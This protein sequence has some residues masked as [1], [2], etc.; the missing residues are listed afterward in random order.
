[1]LQGGQVVRHRAHNPKIVSSILTP[2]TKLWADRL[3][4]TPQYK[5]EEMLV[6][7]QQSPTTVR[8]GKC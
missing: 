8:V 2:A 7:V 3:S 5:C 4:R 6:Q 1:M